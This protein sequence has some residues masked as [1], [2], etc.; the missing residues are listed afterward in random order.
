MA[1]ASKA[2]ALAGTA[3]M[4]VPEAPARSAEIV[5]FQPPMRPAL[6]RVG[7]IARHLANV[8][9]PPLIVLAITL[10]VWQLLCSEPGAR[11]PPPTKVVAD[12]WDFIVDPFYDNGGV[13]KGAFWQITKS[14]G[15]VAI[16][17]SFAAVVGIA[18]GVLIGQSTWAMRGLDPIF[19]VLRTV[20]PLAWLPL[21][22]A[23]FRDSASLG[24][25]RDLHHLDL[26]DHHQHVGGRAGTSRRII[27]TSRRS[28]GCRGG[29]CS[30]RSRCPPRCPTSSPACAS[31]S[32]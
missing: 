27:A 5:A 20:P 28:S 29:R 13:D 11:L 18:L 16:G 10:F 19:Q 9:L 32:A 25:V 31:A 17:F 30:T 14:L 21:S 4:P 8:V 15:R 3:D 12:A 6:E 23:G 26:A 24:A 2:T 22:L 7:E 1:A